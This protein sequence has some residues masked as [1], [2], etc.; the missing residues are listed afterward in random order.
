MASTTQTPSE[1][2]SEYSERL[3]V[4][5]D[6]ELVSETENRVWLSS[7]A[8]NNPRSK[9]H[10]ECDAT[11]DECKRRQ[12]PWLYQRGWNAAYESEG[13][14]L[15]DSDRNAAQEPATGEAK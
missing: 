10:A 2:R 7:Y 4:L 8:A 5:S 6:D 14:T 12:K 1:A 15:S 11:Y 13:H 9:Y 3:K